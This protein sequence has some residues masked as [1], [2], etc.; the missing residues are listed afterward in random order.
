[1]LLAQ[2]II[3]PVVKYKHNIAMINLRAWCKHSYLLIHILKLNPLKDRQPSKAG[4]LYLYKL[5][6]IRGRTRVRALTLKTSG[7]HL[8]E[9]GREG[10]K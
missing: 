3:I 7:I 9:G 2:D 10:K 4:I 1:M 5:C 6:E 8:Q